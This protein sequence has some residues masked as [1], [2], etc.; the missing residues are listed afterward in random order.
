MSRPLPVSLTK[1]GVAP[2]AG[3][4]TTSR[5]MAESSKKLNSFPF[6]VYEMPLSETSTGR[7]AVVV[8]VLRTTKHT[9]VVEEATVI[10]V[11]ALPNLHRMS[12]VLKKLA[13]LM[14][15]ETGYLI[16]N[17]LGANVETSVPGK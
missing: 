2:E 5:E 7:V 12:G 11:V 15:T 9:A 4:R 3:P 13:P 14:V 6:D 8:E 10:A 1:T 17:E 16:R